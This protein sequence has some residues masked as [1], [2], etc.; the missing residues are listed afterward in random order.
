MFYNL[1][2]TQN[3]I[4]III[5]RNRRVAR[6]EFFS[7]RLSWWKFPKILVSVESLPEFEWQNVR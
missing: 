5:I 4:S 6:D 7:T 1:R 2:T 3:D